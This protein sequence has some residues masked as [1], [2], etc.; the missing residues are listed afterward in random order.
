M[1]TDKISSAD[2]AAIQ[3][4]PSLHIVN[5]MNSLR[6]NMINGTDGLLENITGFPGVSALI[7]RDESIGVDRITM[8]AGAAFALH[9]HPGSHILVV[10]EGEGFIS[11]DGADYEVSNADSVY[12]PAVQAHAVQAGPSGLTLIA[13]GYPHVALSSERRMVLVNNEPAKIT[14][15][16]DTQNQISA[17]GVRQADPQ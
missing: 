8:K 11:V 13:F 7:D 6:Q 9:R 3:F 17:E 4:N 5:L 12:V 2:N 14:Y 1:G 10:M 15:D 16:T